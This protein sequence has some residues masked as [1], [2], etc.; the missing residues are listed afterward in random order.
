LVFL[1]YAISSDF[2]VITNKIP[3]W[4]DHTY[5]QPEHGTATSLLQS[6][7][8]CNPALTKLKFHLSGLPKAET[9]ETV[10]KMHFLPLVVNTS[11]LH[12]KQASST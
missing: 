10:S 5:T 11:F 6:L 8:H 12:T 4:T 3:Y 1:L 9:Q 2:I 7:L